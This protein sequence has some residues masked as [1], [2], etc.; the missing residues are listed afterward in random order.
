MV[1]KNNEKVGLNPAF[2]MIELVWVIVILGILAAVAIPRLG[3]TR[4]DAVLVK[5]KSQVA[6]IRSG[7]AMQKSRNLLR[8]NRQTNSY[9]PDNLDVAVATTN[10]ANL[11]YIAP[12]NPENILENPILAVDTLAS[13][14]W[15][16]DNNTTYRLQLTPG[17]VATF[18]YTNTNG[19]FICT[20][21][22]DCTTLTQ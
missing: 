8:G 18:T 12:G 4:D 19:T 11:F 13:G 20:N 22:T 21:S 17:N 7:I 2:T 10:N 6:S 9:Y 3:A 5:G 15:I 16:K 14:R 1:V